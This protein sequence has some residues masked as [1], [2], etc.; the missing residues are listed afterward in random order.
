MRY[1][2]GRTGMYICTVVMALIGPFESRIRFQHVCVP[3]SK[4]LLHKNYPPTL[5]GRRA[6]GKN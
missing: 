6:V 2:F 5:I 3:S 1:S 4:V